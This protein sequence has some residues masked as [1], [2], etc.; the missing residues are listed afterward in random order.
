MRERSVI[1]RVIGLAGLASSK[2]RTGSACEPHCVITSPRPLG[3]VMPNTV[4][5]GWEQDTEVDRTE[6]KMLAR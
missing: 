5:C 1:Q 2:N 6:A 3:Y 4:Q